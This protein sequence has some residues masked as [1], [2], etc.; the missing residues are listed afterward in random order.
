MKK[1]EHRKP[2][3]GAALRMARI[4][5][6]LQA[7][8]FGWPLEDIQRELGVSERTL[9]R[10]LA[11]AK[12]T[13]VD[14]L[15]RPYFDVVAD[16][17]KPRLRLRA[18]HKPVQSTAYQAAS[19]YFTLA[20]LKFLEGTVLKDG[21]DDLWQKFA[22]NLPVF[23]RADL[24]TLDRK[25]YAIQYA[26]KDYHGMD[27]LL[28]PI[29]AGLIREYR[30]RIEYATGLTHEVDPYTLVAYRG[31][32]Y[33]I[34]KTHRNGKITT[35]A[36]ERMVKVE[37]VT[38]DDGACQ[39]FAYPAAF[40]PDHY[41]EGAFGIIVEEQPR[42]VQI[43]IHNTETE[44]YLRARTVHPTQKFSRRRDGKTVLTLTVRG[45][46]ELR[47]WVLGFG[48]WLEVL[49]PPALR[50]EIAGLLKTAS[51]NYE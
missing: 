36:V 8:P 46:T 29:V 18:A 21:V 41:T 38:R 23:E 2:S 47:N 15:R 13:L 50:Q 49:K 10:Y 22:K 19:F 14:R 3:Y 39:K 25:F 11:A 34:G 32:L 12:A 43:L 35:M 37:L 9:K 44:N 24:G 5:F 20:I 40:R 51:G 17:A 48:P 45:T 6:E 27:H 7:H 42:E 4:A 30:L 26:P 31:G 1:Q 16:G 28:N 33:L